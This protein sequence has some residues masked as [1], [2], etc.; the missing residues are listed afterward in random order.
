MSRWWETPARRSNSVKKP[1][2]LIRLIWLPTFDML[3]GSCEIFE[4]VSGIFHKYCALKIFTVWVNKDYLTRNSF[5][6][7]LS[8]WYPCGTI[9]LPFSIMDWVNQHFER[10][11][12]ADFLRKKNHGFSEKKNR[13]FSVHALEQF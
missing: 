10:E 6:V 4:K 2:D 7:V 1:L 8:S 5:L 9:V 3:L 12:I 11:K 13:G